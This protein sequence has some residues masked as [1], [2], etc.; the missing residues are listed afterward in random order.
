MIDAKIPISSASNGD[1]LSRADIAASFQRIA[2]LHLEER[3]E[4][5]ILWAF[6]MEP[7]IRHLVVSGGVAS[8]QYVR[9]RLHYGQGFWIQSMEDGGVSMQQQATIT[10]LY[11]GEI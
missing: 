2:V 3:C 10:S 8:N 7:S 4:R 1:R 11:G 9:A 5:A 6:K